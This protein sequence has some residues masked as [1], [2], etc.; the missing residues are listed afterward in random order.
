[1]LTAISEAPAIRGVLREEVAAVSTLGSSNM[2]L[3]EVPL[4]VADLAEGIVS[5]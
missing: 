5:V 1:M 2:T 3:G 4:E